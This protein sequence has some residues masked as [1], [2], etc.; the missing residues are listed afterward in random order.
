[1]S[2]DFDIS[3]LNRITTII[4]NH[5][6]MVGIDYRFKDIQIRITDCS[7]FKVVNSYGEFMTE[8]EMRKIDS[9]G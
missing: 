5:P 9:E 2:Y 7:T 4:K 3:D 1:M 8:K 6:T